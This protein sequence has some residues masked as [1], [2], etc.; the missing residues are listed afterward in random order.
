MR[1]NHASTSGLEL[2]IAK[3][4]KPQ[5]GK[6]APAVFSHDEATY[7]VDVDQVIVGVDKATAAGDLVKVQILNAGAEVPSE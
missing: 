6:V 5:F 7:K 3:G 1:A 2:D 4:W